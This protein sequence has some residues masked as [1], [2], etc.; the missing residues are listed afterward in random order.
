[1]GVPR[2]CGSHPGGRP[3]GR[4]LD[5]LERADGYDI[6]DIKDK[7]PTKARIPGLEHN[8]K[9]TFGRI[10]RLCRTLS[11]LEARCPELVETDDWQEAV[12]D[13]RSFIAR[14]G[15]Q[16]E[17]LGWTAKDLFGLFPVPPKPHPTFRRLSRYDATGLIWLLR[18]RPVVALTAE[19]AAIES[20]TG[21]ITVYR[22][23][24]GQS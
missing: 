18:G 11:A 6:N 8:Q 2:R 7:T 1:M 24:S 10:S 13:A 14:W 3:M 12:V 15:K 23:H 17:K 16:A 9:D 22:K 4:Y 19:S 20:R 21:A 5:I